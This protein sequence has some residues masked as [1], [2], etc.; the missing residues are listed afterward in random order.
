MWK[1]LKQL[2]RWLSNVAQ[3]SK[4]EEEV[5]LPGPDH[6]GRP[7]LGVVVGH[8]K[9]SQGAT[10]AAPYKTSEYVYHTEIARLMVKMAQDEKMPFDVEVFFRDAG[11]IAGAY[12]DATA[13]GCDAV[14]E[15]HFNGFNAKVKGTVT[16]CSSA[17]QDQEFAW[18]FQNAMCRLFGRG[19][20]SRGV[21]ILS[22]QDRGGF[23]VHSFP[24]GANCLVEPVFGDEPEEAKM[25]VEKKM[26]YV[27]CLLTA[28]YNWAIEKKL[29]Q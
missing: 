24:V 13:A 6:V 20:P 25:Y 5:V 16:L 12:K 23:S 21:K 19:G 8:T 11:G 14:I 15:L 2:K 9:A 1:K 17:K 22:R 27:R 26:E 18:Y 10:L 29:I 28:F 4:K 3:S 7:K